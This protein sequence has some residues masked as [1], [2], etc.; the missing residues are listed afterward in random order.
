MRVVP[1]ALATFVLV[2]S[3]P[4]A[5]SLEAERGSV[6]SPE[7]AAKLLE[8]APSEKLQLIVRLDG[9][10]TEDDARDLRAMGITLTSALSTVPIYGAVGTRAAVMTAAKDDRVAYMELD[11]PLQYHLATAGRVARARDVWDALPGGQPVV[12]NGQVID[13]SGVGVAVVDS[14]VDATHPDLEWGT[15]VKKNYFRNVALANTLFSPPLLPDSVNFADVPNSDFTS[16]HGTHVA[17]TVGG[18]GAVSGGL[19]KGAA[20]GATI[21]GYGMG[22]GIHI[23]AANEAFD[24]ILRN[25]DSFDPPIKVVTNSYGGCGGRW[26]AS[27][28]TS[29]LVGMLLEKDVN[30]VWSAGNIDDTCTDLHGG[31]AADDP[32]PGVISVGNYDGSGANGRDGTID[33]SSSQGYVDE[34]PS[35][36]PDVAAPGTEIVAAAATTGAL[37]IALGTPREYATMSGTSMAAPMVAGVIALVRQ[38][39]PDLSAADVEQVL[40]RTAYKYDADIDQDVGDVKR[41][42]GL[43]DA[44]AAV[45]AV[46]GGLGADAGVQALSVTSDGT[47]KPILRTGPESASGDVTIGG[48]VLLFGRPAPTYSSIMLFFHRTPTGS[49]VNPTGGVLPFT[50]VAGET[51]AT[52]IRQVT[53]IAGAPDPMNMSVR[54][55]ARH[56]DTG[57]VLFDLPCNVR[58]VNDAV[59]GVDK[60]CTVVYN[61]TVADKTGV[62]EVVATTLLDGSPVEIIVENVVIVSA[63]GSG[64]TFVDPGPRAPVRPGP[65]AGDAITVEAR[66]DE[67]AWTAA[68]L[69]GSQWSVDLTVPDGGGVLEVRATDGVANATDRVVFGAPAPELDL[70][71]DG[72]ASAPTGTAVTFDAVV[73]GAGAWTFEWDSDHDGVTFDVDGTGPSFT[74]TYAT[75]GTYT[76]AVRANDGAGTTLNATLDHAAF[77]EATL[78]DVTYS[79]GAAVPVSLATAALGHEAGVIVRD[80]QAKRYP[81]VLPA[82]VTQLTV[83]VSWQHHTVY[84]ELVGLTAN[85]FDVWIQ[86]PAGGYD[87]HGGATFAH[88]ERAVIASPAAGRYNIDI[89]PFLVTEADTVRVVVKTVSA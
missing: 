3:F 28:A 25:F 84:N 32:R 33:P 75:R 4:V 57:D 49:G 54:M 11:L 62:Y 80:P 17:G 2:A 12:M 48:D 74:T 39:N 13:G 26:S 64:E 56:M 83:E 30:V 24:H 14:G 78:F 52:E 18:S 16:G 20:P 29:I 8:V 87:S 73:T 82:G 63:G 65:L 68:T 27:S 72:P 66:F 43:V 36:W 23:L 34:P 69:T 40:R 37:S 59:F 76:V 6:L 77:A 85:D 35:M 42:V 46:T 89:A 47:G 31:S 50:F 21:Y 53:A 70:A 61:V 38:A 7:L 71:I 81:V 15:H 55:V 19:H 88:G 67:D 44:F 86:D 22:Q 41:G 5:S 60:R 58:G 10:A 9:F 45:H 51:M 1:L 79:Q